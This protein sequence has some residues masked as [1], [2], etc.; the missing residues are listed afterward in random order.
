MILHH[1]LH[2]TAH[3]CRCAEYCTFNNN[4]HTVTQKTNIRLLLKGYC[5]E[6]LAL[7]CLPCLVQLLTWLHVFTVIFGTLKYGILESN[8]LALNNSTAECNKVVS[9]IFGKFK[10]LMKYQNMGSYAHFAPFLKTII[11]L[12][13]KILRKNGVKSV[14]SVKKKCTSSLMQ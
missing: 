12:V 11:L 8:S 9:D 6:S 1:Y 14:V 10:F 4:L 5:L 3:F 7:T 2:H 13:S